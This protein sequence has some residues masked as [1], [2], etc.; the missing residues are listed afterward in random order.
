MKRK[1]DIKRKKDEYISLKEAAKLSGYSSD[2]IGYLIRTKK[3]K[4]KSISLGK[5]WVINPETVLNYKIKKKK[6][7]KI[8][9]NLKIKKFFWSK[10]LS[11]FLPAFKHNFSEGLHY[12]LSYLRFS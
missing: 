10:K 5:T 8:G 12:A 4:G 7:K 11:R 2:Y 9:K 1:K 6:E 3:I